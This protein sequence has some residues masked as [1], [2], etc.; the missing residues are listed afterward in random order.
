[1]RRIGLALMLVT[2]AIA[3]VATQWRFH[4]DLSGTGIHRRWNDIDW[5]WFPRTPRGHI[6]VD[7]DLVLNLLMLMPLGIGFAIW[8]RASGWRVV[9]EALLLGVLVSSALELGQLANM[10]R[11]TT[12]ADVWRNALGCAVGAAIEVA[13]RR[14]ARIS[15]TPSAS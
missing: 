6:R 11:Y 15:A 7:R 9:I 3:V 12:F 13:L 5:R 4:F 10:Y 14:A 8:R 2:V 1:M